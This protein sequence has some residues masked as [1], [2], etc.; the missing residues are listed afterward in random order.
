MR[1]SLAALVVMLAIGAARAED[2]TSISIDQM[3]GA[4]DGG[5][6]HLSRAHRIHAIRWLAGADGYIDARHGARLAVSALTTV[7][8][9]YFS[10]C[11]QACSANQEPIPAQR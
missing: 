11:A 2:M 5:C 10:W 4:F 9:A 3:S 7:D 1:T 8:A 6:V